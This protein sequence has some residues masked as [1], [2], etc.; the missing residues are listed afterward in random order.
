MGSTL[1][2]RDFV[3]RPQRTTARRGHVVD[4]LRQGHLHLHRVCMVPPVARGCT[5]GI[6]L[7]RQSA[8]CE[9]SRDLTR[10]AVAPPPFARES[11]A[12]APATAYTVD[13]AKSI[14]PAG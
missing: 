14:N 3:A 12:G 10:P 1:P 4:P 2:D 9:V 7:V 11:R 13:H 6:P 5:R 8:E